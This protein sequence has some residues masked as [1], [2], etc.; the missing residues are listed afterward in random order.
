L[1]PLS[2]YQKLVADYKMLQEKLAFYEGSGSVPPTAAPKD[3]QLESR[4]KNG[5]AI[6]GIHPLGFTF[7]TI[8]NN[9]LPQ[10]HKAQAEYQVQGL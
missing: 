6:F 5:F 4:L 7:C 10:T 9:R 2:D 1:S 3:A 8:I